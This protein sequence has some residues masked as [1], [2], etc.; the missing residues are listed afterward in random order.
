M[1]P[2]DPNHSPRTSYHLSTNPSLNFSW[3]YPV[4][5]SYILHFSTEIASAWFSS[6]VSY[7]TVGS[8]T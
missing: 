1:V 3:R 2:R 6:F 8:S 7:R 4:H 5:F